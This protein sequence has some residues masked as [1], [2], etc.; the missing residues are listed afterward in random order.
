MELGDERVGVDD[1]SARGV[2]EDR[3][4]PQEAERLASNQ[5]AGRVGQRREHDDR[6]GRREQVGQLVWAVQVV[7]R[8]R[9]DA[10]HARADGLQ[11]GAQAPPDR[12]H[13]R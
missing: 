6:V 7:V 1:R 13:P 11:E 12:A 9:S 8:V 4:V 5:P 3:A 10:D 2:D